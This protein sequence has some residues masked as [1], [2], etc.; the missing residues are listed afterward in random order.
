MTKNCDLDVTVTRAR[1]D[2]LDE[3][4]GL[5]DR[6]VTFLPAVRIH[7]NDLYRTYADVT[8]DVYFIGRSVIERDEYKIINSQNYVL[9]L[10]KNEAIKHIG[11]GFENKYDEVDNGNM[12]GHKYVGYLVVLRNR[13]GEV[14]YVKSNRNIWE[15]NAHHVIDANENR[16]YISSFTDELE[17]AR[18]Q[19]GR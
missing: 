3:E 17:P 7:N 12:F 13:S 5:D 18:Y 15:E 9:D 10:P 19:R 16:V 14:V 1:D 2:E 8:V 4:E 11:K 6:S